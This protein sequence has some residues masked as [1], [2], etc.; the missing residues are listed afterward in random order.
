VTG[1][2]WIGDHPLSPSLRHLV[3]H[4]QAYFAEVP[5]LAEI[6]ECRA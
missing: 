5:P 4:P 6:C 3:T 1:Y 2:W